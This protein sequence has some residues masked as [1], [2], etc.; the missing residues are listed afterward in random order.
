MTLIRG[1]DHYEGFIR[2]LGWRHQAAGRTSLDGLCGAER[3]VGKY[4]DSILELRA[5]DCH[6]QHVAVLGICE[7]RHVARVG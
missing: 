7:A 1:L 5:S 3:D 6:E 4:A 2:D